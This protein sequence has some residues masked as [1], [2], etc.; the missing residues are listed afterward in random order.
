MELYMTICE[1]V[2]NALVYVTVVFK[3]DNRIK[4]RGDELYEPDMSL[5]SHMYRS[6]VGTQTMK[7]P[8]TRPYSLY[9]QYTG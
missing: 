8:W 2:T 7:Q 3:D 5:S 9:P 6:T 4:T 1:I